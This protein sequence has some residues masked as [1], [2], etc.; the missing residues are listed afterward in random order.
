MRLNSTRVRQLIDGQATNQCQLARQMG[1]SRGAMS[2]ALAGRRAAGK[3]LLAGLLR[4]FPD[5]T[6][7]TIT[8]PEKRVAI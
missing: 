6:I 8:L 2:N 1:I 7:E 4:A 3:K 5:E